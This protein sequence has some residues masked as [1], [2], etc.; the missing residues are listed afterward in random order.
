[1]LFFET[2]KNIESK[3]FSLCEIIPG[4]SDKASGRLLQVDCIFFKDD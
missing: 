1:M 3:G 4:F 2:I